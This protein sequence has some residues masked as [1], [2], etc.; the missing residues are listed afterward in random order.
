MELLQI[1]KDVDLW[2]EVYLEHYSWRSF[3]RGVSR[4]RRM[5]KNHRALKVEKYNNWKEQRKYE[6]SE[7]SGSKK[8]K[9]N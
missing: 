7:S 8:E 1:L 4:E 6:S 9:Q 5:W 3:R 2:V